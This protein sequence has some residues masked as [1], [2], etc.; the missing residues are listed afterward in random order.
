MNV[1][2]KKALDVL[3]SKLFWKSHFSRKIGVYPKIVTQWADNYNLSD[4]DADAILFSI[5]PYITAVNNAEDVFDLR[6]V[7]NFKTLCEMADVNYKQTLKRVREGISIPQEDQERVKD[8]LN[9]LKKRWDYQSLYK[10]MVEVL[11]KN[12]TE[13]HPVV[14][15]PGRYEYQGVTYDLNNPGQA[16]FLYEKL[17]GESEKSAANED[18]FKFH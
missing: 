6:A 13:L 4:D 1:M 14:D 16:K 9:A 11:T 2:A 12:I 5:H 18:P 3:N 10:K 17:H 8:T 7:F 15:I